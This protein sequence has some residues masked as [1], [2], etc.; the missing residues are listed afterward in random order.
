[1]NLKT[2]KCPLRFMFWKC[3]KWPSCSVRLSGRSN[4]WKKIAFYACQGTWLWLSVPGET[5]DFFVF[6]KKKRQNYS[7]RKFLSTNRNWIKK[8]KKKM[9]KP[10]TFCCHPNF[11]NIFLN[12][13][14]LLYFGF[15]MLYFN[16]VELAQLFLCAASAHVVLVE[17]FMY[18]LCDK[19]IFKL[20]IN[21]CC[22]YASAVI[23]KIF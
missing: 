17:S 7:S 4:K 16:I 15:Y 10:S 2:W 6:S 20:K 1:M 3:C 22:L 12:R 21:G 11:Y 18:A 8:W 23:A 9:Q 19:M 13:I 5:S 14:H